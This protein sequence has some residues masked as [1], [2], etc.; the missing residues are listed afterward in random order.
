MIWQ[1]RVIGNLSGS[2]PDDVVRVHPC[3]HG[4]Q[5]KGKERENDK[6]F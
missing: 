6:E 2:Y 5:N 4:P 1:G 3:N